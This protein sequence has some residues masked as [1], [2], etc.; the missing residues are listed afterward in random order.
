MIKNYLITA[1]RNLKRNKVYTFLNVI[2]LALGIGCA[3]VIFKVIRYELSF[4]KHHANFEY[5]YRVVNENIYPDRVDKGQ[6]TPHPL[7]PALVQDYPELEYVVR[8][9]YAY[10]DQINITDENDEFQKFL[11]EEGVAFTENNFFKIFSTECA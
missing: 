5:I 3:L 11:I 2:G 10:G 4:D 9:H 7:G 8:T 6:G 1:L